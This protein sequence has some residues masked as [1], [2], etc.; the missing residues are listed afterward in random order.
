[1]TNWLKNSEQYL[2]SYYFLGINEFSLTVMA[3]ER[4]GHQLAFDW[5]KCDRYL[6][7]RENFIDETKKVLFPFD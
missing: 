2:E 3:N 4:K 5:I 6:E 1:M 7:N